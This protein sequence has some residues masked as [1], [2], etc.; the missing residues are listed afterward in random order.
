MSL[1]AR[2]ST[3]LGS[4]PAQVK[5]GYGM[6]LDIGETT[7]LGIAMK[8]EHAR[9]KGL[10]ESG[11]PSSNRLDEGIVRWYF[12]RCYPA[13]VA[14]TL[15]VQDP[16]TGE[17]SIV[18]MVVGSVIHRGERLNDI[19]KTYAYNLPLSSQEEQD[20]LETFK[21]EFSIKDAIDWN[22]WK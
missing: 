4:I 3:N 22:H 14:H 21:K 9:A 6:L 16:F 10:N 2:A 7:A 17:V 18:F 13:L 8:R 5:V 1:S 15:K 20:D 19:L 11:V 12:H